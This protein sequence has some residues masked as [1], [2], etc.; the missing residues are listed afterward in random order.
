MTDVSDVRLTLPLT[1]H[2]ARAVRSAL[3]GTAR[4]F[5]R[6][7]EKGAFQPQEG[8][9][10]RNLKG[11]EMNAA[12]AERLDT[13]LTEAI[14]SQKAGASASASGTDASA[15]KVYELVN[16]SDAIC[17][18]ATPFEARCIAA[19]LKAHPGLVID[20]ETK[21]H[22]SP[23]DDPD[24]TP[25][26]EA[27]WKSAEAIQ[28]YARA[29]G[30]FMCFPA[31]NRVLLEQALSRTPDDEADLLRRRISENNR[32][33]LNDICRICRDA[34]VNIAATLPEGHSGPVP[35]NE[36]EPD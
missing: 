24:F 18:I 17:F 30:S 36:A 26:Y 21:D 28:S 35:R 25:K 12:I 3:A 15:R 2:E 27:I 34:A 20:P 8:R 23:D 6:A 1:Y 19:R 13:R 29:W 9:I 10:D 31:R 11:A 33:S 16:P 32:T 5:A 22:I 4:K 14:A 7:A